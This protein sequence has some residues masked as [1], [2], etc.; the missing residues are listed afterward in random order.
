MRDII[1][2]LLDQRAV[3]GVFLLLALVASGAKPS[4]TEIVIMIMLIWIMG[5]ID[6]LRN[7]L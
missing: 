5:D 7:K 1:K 3:Q 2:S 6:K 4:T